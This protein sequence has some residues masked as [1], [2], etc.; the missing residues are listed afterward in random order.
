[1]PCQLRL[2]PCFGSWCGYWVSM[3]CSA[4]FV[5]S[6]PNHC[7]EELYI[8]LVA[9][10]VLLSMRYGEEIEDCAVAKLVAGAQYCIGDVVSRGEEGD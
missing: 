7:I 2:D 3:R 4:W 10:K 6:H 1:M 9:A 8:W 5:F